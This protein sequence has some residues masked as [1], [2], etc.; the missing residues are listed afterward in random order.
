MYIQLFNE[1]LQLVI[2]NFNQSAQLQFVSIATSTLAVLV[3]EVKFISTKRKGNFASP[4]YPAIA[5]LAPLGLVLLLAILIGTIGTLTTFQSIFDIIFSEVAGNVTGAVKIL[6]SAFIINIL[7]VI[8]SFLIF[9]VP[10][11]H[12]FFIISRNLLY[13]LVATASA[14]LNTWMAVDDQGG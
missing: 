11:T 9:I 4:D 1:L 6:F 8:S 12:K 14:I 5:S 2:D 13:L 3:A 7:A 10:L